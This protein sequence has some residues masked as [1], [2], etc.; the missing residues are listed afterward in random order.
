LFVVFPLPEALPAVTEIFN[1][2]SSVTPALNIVQVNF[3][4]LKTVH[5]TKYYIKH[6]ES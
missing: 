1:N 3:L 4:S 5:L 2:H 6:K